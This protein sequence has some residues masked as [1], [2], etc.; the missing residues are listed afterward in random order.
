MK[1]KST[2]QTVTGTISGLKVKLDSPI[3]IN[4]A[5]YQDTITHVDVPGNYEILSMQGGAGP[6]S[7]VR[8][9]FKA[10][11]KSQGKTLKRSEPGRRYLVPK[12]RFGPNVAANNTQK[13][14]N[15]LNLSRDPSFRKMKRE[16]K[17]YT[18]N[19]IQSR[20]SGN[21]TRY[22][23]GKNFPPHKQYLYKKFAEITQGR[24]NVG[25]MMRAIRVSNLSYED[26]ARLEQ[27]VLNLY[28]NLNAKANNN[29]AN[30][31]NESRTPLIP[32]W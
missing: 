18:R 4:A 26:Q 16:N 25:S 6:Q 32:N 3:Q 9:I 19:L 12:F 31:T 14:V 24:N 28:G 7:H 1:R 21:F 5:G 23:P 11:R 17:N 22:S 2:G 27:R 30:F 15:V 20:K 10:I 13:Q 29:Y 8:N